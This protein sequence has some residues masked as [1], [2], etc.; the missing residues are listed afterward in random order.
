MVWLRAALRFAKIGVLKIDTACDIQVQV[1]PSDDRHMVKEAIVMTNGGRKDAV[2]AFIPETVPEWLVIE[3]A[4]CRVPAGTSVTVNV[5]VLPSIAVANA[6]ERFTS[7][8][9]V[10]RVENGDDLIFPISCSLSHT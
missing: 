4:V 2:A 7:A 6:V 3:P 9:L 10:C 1:R 8:L 5:S